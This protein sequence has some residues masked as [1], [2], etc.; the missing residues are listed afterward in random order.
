MTGAID[1][2]VNP[3]M[4]AFAND[5]LVRDVNDTL[6]RAENLFADLS[7]RD[8]IAAMDDAGVAHAVVSVE[9]EDPKDWILDFS[10]SHPERFSLGAWVNI[11]HGM[12]A[13]WAMRDLAQR[14]KVVMARVMPS[15]HDKPPT[16]ASYYP[17]FAKCAEMNLPVSVL[18]GIPGPRLDA[19][20]QDPI[21]LDRVCRDFPMLTIVMTHG[22][23]PWWDTAI[24]LMMKYPNLYLMTSAWLPKYLPASLISYMN[25]RGREKI[26]WASDHPVLDMKRALGAVPALDLRDGVKERYLHDNARTV[27]K[28]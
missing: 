15:R 25:T 4:A 2:F 7:A 26:M 1:L 13:V 14:E 12:D 28:L 16:H 10:R 20:S 19:A 8:L 5:P 27:F 24:R 22:A 18:T 6:F 21:H 3:N 9:A 17:L 11:D 23:D